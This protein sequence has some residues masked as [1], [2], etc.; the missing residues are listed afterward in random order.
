[1]KMKK[2]FVA[3]LAMLSLTAGAQTEV[4]N[5]VPGLTENGITYFLP[6]TRLHITLTATRKS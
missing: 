3:V 2:M 1:M 4:S 6:K 5:Y